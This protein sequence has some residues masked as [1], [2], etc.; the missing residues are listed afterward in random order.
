MAIQLTVFSALFSKARLYLDT[1]THWFYWP[2]CRP[3]EIWTLQISHLSV[4]LYTLEVACVSLKHPPQFWQTEI[5]EPQIILEWN[6]RI[7]GQKSKLA[8][9]VCRLF[10][11]FKLMACIQRRLEWS[12]CPNAFHRWSTSLWRKQNL[13]LML[14]TAR[15]PIIDYI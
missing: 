4:T 7:L 6:H 8:F 13:H 1:W 2:S 5:E 14:R 12:W 15:V 11:R 3:N 10:R 9:S